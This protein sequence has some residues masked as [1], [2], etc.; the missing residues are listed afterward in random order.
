MKSPPRDNIYIVSF[1]DWVE[2]F[3]VPDK[4]AK[5]VADLIMGEI[6]PRYGAPVCLVTDNGPENV[7]Y[8]MR[9]V[10]TSLNMAHNISYHPQSNARVERV[11]RTLRDI[12]AKLARDNVADWD[13]YLTGPRD[14]T[15]H[16]Q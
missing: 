15:V 4:K 5:T 13:L 9:E 7:N 3:A 14:G 10:A 11:H 1:V 8:V 2:A 6:F 12:L 16:N